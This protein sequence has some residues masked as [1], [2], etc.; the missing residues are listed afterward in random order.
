MFG[1]NRSSVIAMALI[2]ILMAGSVLIPALASTAP[3]ESPGAPPYTVL[4]KY[5][6]KI[7]IN[8]KVNYPSGGFWMGNSD[9]PLGGV[10]DTNAFVNNKWAS[11]QVYC[12]DP[13][14]GFHSD[15]TTTK[16]GPVITNN[17]KGGETWGVTTTDRYAGYYPAADWA[18]SGAMR[19]Y[20]DAIRWLTYNGYRGDFLFHDQESADSLTRLN[21]LYGKEVRE[22]N[23]TVAV[24]A[25]KYAMWRVLTDDIP[26][27]LTLQS[28][29]LDGT[30]DRLAFDSLVEL[31]VRDAKAQRNT[32]GASKNY[33]KLTM[34]IKDSDTPPATLG[35]Y[36]FYGPLS[37]DVGLDNPVSASDAAAL[38]I[39]KVFLTVGGLNST[40]VKLVSATNA[41]DASVLPVGK[42]PGSNQQAQYISV[43]NNGGVIKSGEFYLRI[44]AQRANS[45]DLLTV[46]AKGVS[47]NVPVAEGTPAVIA[48]ES[49]GVQDW[50]HIQAF[51]GASAKGMKLDLYAEDSISTGL[52]LGEIYIS[53]IVENASPSDENT[54][55]TFKVFYSTSADFSDPKVLDLKEHP[56]HPASVV[57]SDGVSIILKNGGMV[58]IGNLPI[59]GYYYRVVET[60]ASGFD[61]PKITIPYAKLPVKNPQAAT[62]ASGGWST[63][64]FQIDDDEDMEFAFVT[65]TNVKKT[66]MAHLQVGKV[67]VWVDGNGKIMM[68]H[69][70]DDI[71][72]FKIE[73][74]DNSRASW[75]PY[76]LINNVNFHVESRSP[77]LNTGQTTSGSGWIT[78]GLSGEFE[79]HH[80]ALA[81]IDVVPDRIYRVTEDPGDDY[82]S[83]Y[84][85][86][87]H[88]GSQWVPV[89]SN[90]S[91]SYWKSRGVNSTADMGGI[92][93]QPDG[94]YMVLFTNTH[95]DA[96]ELIIKKTV[97]SSGD[98]NKL[99]G[100][101]VIYVGDSL[102]VPTPW[103]VPLTTDPDV[104][105][106][107]YVTYTDGSPLPAT[108]IGGADNTIVYLKHDESVTVHGLPSGQ[109]K[110][111]ELSNSGYVTAYRI[112]TSS[113]RTASSNVTRE[114]DFASDTR[115]DFINTTRPSTPGNPEEPF[116]PEEPEVPLI[117]GE[118]EETTPT[119]TTPTAPT[120]PTGTGTTPTGTTSPTTTTP[121]NTP[122]TG[123]DR[124]PTLDIVLLSLGFACVV[125]A[126]IY[127]RRSRR[128]DAPD[129]GNE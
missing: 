127:R 117:P 62:N 95:A 47:R 126:E 13:F 57:G 15:A 14:I 21:N 8:Y 22:I 37:V 43:T 80:Y 65:F 69:V 32:G 123:D 71:F 29:S 96:P 51:V 49:G 129:T 55:F 3:P 17:Y 70:T 72:D 118:P 53:K 106:A 73:Y 87:A 12:V 36:V 122:Q 85:I 76:P 104:I 11:S 54:E 77:R 20:G 42:V 34:S 93:F 79:L 90:P 45:T 121:G 113:Y 59:D 26:D 116:E 108:R 25:T 44:P 64:V 99:F 110:I 50:E 94:D 78:N 81:F 107:M 125:G 16:E 5:Y 35:D 40:N 52:N 84:I 31:L 4:V 119:A 39:D 101:E 23:K 112:N 24:M 18:M 74:R 6:D 46:N 86:L 67:A 9:I 124:N 28:T 56:V 105:G 2:V 102:R 19:K 75:T 7:M 92:P 27:A 88:N 128:T 48:Y 38:D 1:R 89:T 97:E 103:A 60:T 63:P 58:E 61:T 100:F 98:R 83:A 41:S 30:G 120:T 82:A 115:V 33:T 109:Y 66:R 111:R 114:F 91:S 68:D 10:G